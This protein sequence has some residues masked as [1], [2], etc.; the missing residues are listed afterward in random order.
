M[1]L[2]FLKFKKM[3]TQEH[4]AD[5]TSHLL[6]VDREELIEWLEIAPKKIRPINFYRTRRIPKGIDRKADGHLRTTAGYKLGRK[7]QLEGIIEL[8]RNY[9]K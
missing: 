5:N 8:I 1:P 9:K 6:T 7:E 3:T 4:P 2:Y